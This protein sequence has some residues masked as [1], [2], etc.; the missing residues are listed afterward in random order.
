MR[1]SCGYCDIFDVLVSCH[2]LVTQSMRGYDFYRHKGSA[3]RLFDD[4]Y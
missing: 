1:K 4:F 2:P 3:K